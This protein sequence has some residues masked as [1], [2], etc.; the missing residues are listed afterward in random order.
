MVTTND[1][2]ASSQFGKL[3]ITQCFEHAH[4]DA[5]RKRVVSKPDIIGLAKLESNHSIS[6]S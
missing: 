2:N 4:T 5:G 1:E 3:N 6:G